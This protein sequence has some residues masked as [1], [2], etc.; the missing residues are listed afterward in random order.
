MNLTGGAHADLKCRPSGRYAAGQQ[1]QVWVPQRREQLDLMQQL[2][3]KI[4]ASSLRE[5]AGLD[6]DCWPQAFRESLS[7][8]WAQG[9]AS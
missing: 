4:L 7:V 6:S 2:F 3:K 1:H 9:Q 8:L 5:H